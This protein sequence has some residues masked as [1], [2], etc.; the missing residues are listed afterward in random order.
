MTN[1]IV[2]PCEPKAGKFQPYPGTKQ[3]LDKVVD[4][5]NPVDVVWLPILHEPGANCPDDKV[6]EKTDTGCWPRR[7]HKYPF[8]NSKRKSSS[9]QSILCL[10]IQINYLLSPKSSNMFA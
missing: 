4:N 9:T 3:C 6:I 7:G 2:L 8:I 10:S 5:L 1:P